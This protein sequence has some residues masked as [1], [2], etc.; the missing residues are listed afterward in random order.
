MKKILLSILVLL[1]GK[2][3]LTGQTLS[4]DSL[5]HHDNGEK[6]YLD[7]Q[8]DKIAAFPGGES[9]MMSWLMHSVK[10]PEDA[11]KKN[12]QG[13]VYGT[14]VVETDGSLTDLKILKSVYPSLDKEF[15][16][17][18]TSSPK[19]Q[20]ATKDG[21]PVRMQFIFPLKFKLD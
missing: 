14:F 6:I 11:K 15:I 21:I 8:V 13:T 7:Q 3:T 18:F 1:M 20:P 12:A 19:W 5:Y 9:Q 16:R 4:R 10:Y 2:L 17:V